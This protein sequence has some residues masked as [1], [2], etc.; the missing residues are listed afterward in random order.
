MNGFQWLVKAIEVKSKKSSSC[1]ARHNLKTVS[2]E[3][4]TSFLSDIHHRRFTLHSDFS[5]GVWH[6]PIPFYLA[7]LS[8]LLVAFE[9]DQ[10][11]YRWECFAILQVHRKT[12]RSGFI[13]DQSHVTFFQPRPFRCELIPLQ[14]MIRM[15]TDFHSFQNFFGKEWPEYGRR[16][17]RRTKAWYQAHALLQNWLSTKKLLEKPNKR[18][19]RS[20]ADLSH[21]NT[22]RFLDGNNP[23]NLQ[24]DWVF[25]GLILHTSDGMTEW[26]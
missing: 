1:Q 14:P 17:R 6:F 11:G 15:E 22:R 20:A 21:K 12:K 9:R 10:F 16:W 8:N 4:T 18:R 23:T 3:I 2:R 13:D 26:W 7:F 19:Q 25:Q 24:V 5:G